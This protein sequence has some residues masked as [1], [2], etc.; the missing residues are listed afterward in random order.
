[1]FFVVSEDSRLKR[2]NLLCGEFHYATVSN[3]L[4]SRNPRNL[5]KQLIFL[6]ST[7]VR[8]AEANAGAVH[9]T[10]EFSWKKRF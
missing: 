1:M 3:P 9:D 6:V 8:L 10:P 4:P 5:Q 7:R 2:V